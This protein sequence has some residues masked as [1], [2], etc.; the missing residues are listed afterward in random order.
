MGDTLRE[1]TPVRFLTIDEIDR[2]RLGFDVP[3]EGFTCHPAAELGRIG[4]NSSGGG[5]GLNPPPASTRGRPALRSAQC[6]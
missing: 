2:L 3:L 4:R 6:V 1:P 5:E